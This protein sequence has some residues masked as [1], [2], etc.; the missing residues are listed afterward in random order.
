MINTVTVKDEHYPDG[1]EDQPLVVLF[2]SG[3]ARRD[4]GPVVVDVYPEV[5]YFIH[6]WKNFCNRTDPEVWGEVAQVGVFE[7]RW[8]NVNGT[9]FMKGTFRHLTAEEATSLHLP[10]REWPRWRLVTWKDAAYFFITE[11]MGQFR[12]VTFS[13]VKEDKPEAGVGDTIFFTVRGRAYKVRAGDGHGVMT[14]VD[15]DFRR[16]FTRYQ[17]LVEAYK[18]AD[19]NAYKD[20]YRAPAGSP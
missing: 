17:E 4:F 7:G 13:D 8:I 12:Q 16:E 11:V 9:T 6:E 2:A 20:D 10:L 15:G 14:A 5:P 3:L 18:D 19:K 1:A